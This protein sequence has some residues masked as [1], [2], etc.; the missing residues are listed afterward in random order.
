MKQI[1]VCTQ[2][3]TLQELRKHGFSYLYKLKLLYYP[4]DLTQN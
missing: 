3:S 4:V 1:K 2:Y